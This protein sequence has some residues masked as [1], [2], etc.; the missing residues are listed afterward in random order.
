MTKAMTH[1][2][3]NLGRNQE[4]VYGNVILSPREKALLL[5]FVL[6]FFAVNLPLTPIQV[7]ESMKMVT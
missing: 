2:Y 6:S 3:Y 7:E 5:G 4:N 1:I